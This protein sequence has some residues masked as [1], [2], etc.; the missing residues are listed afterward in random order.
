[1]STNLFLTVN[2]KSDASTSGDMATQMMLGHV[3]A[4]LHPN[5]KSVLIIGLGSGVTAGSVLQHPDVESVEVVEMSPDVIRAAAFF[6][7]HNHDAL[8]HSR[9]KLIHE[10]AK[11]HLLTA[12]RTRMIS[13][14]ANLPIHGWP[15]LPACSPA[16]TLHP[17]AST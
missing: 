16:S 4:L 1:M 13:S 2:G 15:E 8:N 12:G 7:D 11:A 6:R 14:S 10:D 5:P 17:A 3:P 9:L